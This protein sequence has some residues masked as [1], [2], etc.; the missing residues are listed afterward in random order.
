MQENKTERKVHTAIFNANL[1]Y[2]RIITNYFNFN[3][4]F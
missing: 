2:V 1:I 3:A 4:L